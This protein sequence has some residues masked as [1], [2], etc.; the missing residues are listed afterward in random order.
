MQ[1]GAG[2]VGQRVRE[3]YETAREAVAQ[4]YQ[5]AE[6]MIARNPASSVMIGFGLGFGLG[7]LLTLALTQRE[8]SPWSG[9]SLGDS[10]RHIPER[11]RHVPDSIAR[12]MPES[13]ARH[14]A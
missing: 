10:F 13:I 2:Q 9:W 7:I 4:R 14:M 8:E 12:H 11:L 5:R 6:G 1:E 3:G